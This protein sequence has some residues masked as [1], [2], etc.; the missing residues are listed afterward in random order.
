M[1]PNPCLR[2]LKVDCGRLD[3]TAIQLLLHPSLHELCLIN[4]ADFSGKLLSE[5]G[6]M[7]KDLRF[8]LL[9]EISL[10]EASACML[11]RELI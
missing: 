8:E 2:S 5:I 1:P 10:L 4:C 7:C 3:D 9:L 6:G 11:D